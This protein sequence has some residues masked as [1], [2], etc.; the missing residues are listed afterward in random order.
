MCAKV[1]RF[2]SR[3]FDLFQVPFSAPFLITFETLLGS[4]FNPFSVIFDYFLVLFGTSISYRFFIG[5]FMDFGTLFHA[6]FDD[7]L[8]KVQK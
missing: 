7:L 8:S 2:F 5:F 6:I 3:N 4:I 1:E